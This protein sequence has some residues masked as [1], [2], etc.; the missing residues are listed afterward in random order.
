VRIRP[1]VNVIALGAI[2]ATPALAQTPAASDQQRRELRYQI[3]QFERSLEGAVEHG[4][5]IARER[6]QAALPTQMLISENAHVRGF[7]LEGYGVFFDVEVPGLE[8]SLLWGLRML[9]Q[10]DLGLQS[11][12]NDLKNF[13]TSKASGDA[14]LEQAL[15]R[16]EL[17]IAPAS[18]T[19]APVVPGARFQSGTPASTA[20]DD[21]RATIRG[22]DLV[23]SDPNDAFHVEIKHQIMKAMLDYS[24]PLDVRPDEWLTI[25]ARRHDERPAIAPADTDARTVV[26]RV[27]GGDLTAFRSGQLSREEALKKMDVHEF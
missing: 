26:I 14:K 9:D 21:Q 12:L 11:A 27:R 10:N 6:V 2:A 17:Q 22:A 16:V 25:A 20:A 24:S 7:R 8:G 5:N 3:S 23:V 18:I 13:V 4:A 15:R 19:T 1:I